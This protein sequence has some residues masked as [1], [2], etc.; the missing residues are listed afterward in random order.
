MSKNSNPNPNQHIADYL[1]HYL[2]Q[3]NPPHY[4]VMID[5]PWGIGKTFFIKEL[6]QK[7]FEGRQDYVYISLYGLETIE[8]I[9]KTLLHSLYPILF[10]KSSKIV[11]KVVKTGL[12]YFGLN[13]K[14]E[15][16]IDDALSKFQAKT[17]VFDDLERSSI[18]LKKVMGY[19]NEFI[20][21][22][23]CKVIVIANSK[24]IKKDDEQVFQEQKE[25]IIGRTF[26]AQSELDNALQKFIEEISD[27]STREIYIK[28][29]NSIKNIYEQS[30]L[31]NL[32]ILQQVLWDFERLYIKIK[33]NFK[34]EDSAISQLLK[35]FFALSYEFRS[36]RI[37]SQDLRN[38]LNQIVSGLTL[39]RKN[40]ELTPFTEANNRYS[41]IELYD[42]I[43]SDEVLEEILIKGIIDPVKINE[44]LS[45]SECFLDMPEEPSWRKLWRAIELTDI[46]FENAFLDFNDKFNAG[47]YS[48]PGE[49]LHVFGIRLW[50][51][52]MGYFGNS[53]TNTE[54]D[55]KKYV[56]KL[57]AEEKLEPLPLN[58]SYENFQ[59]QGYAGLAVHEN[60]TNELLNTANYL[61]SKREHLLTET[62]PKL[63]E[64]LLRELSDDVSLFHRRINITNS[65][66]NLYYDTPIF[67]YI[68]PENFIKILL[69]LNPKSQIRALNSFK[70]RYQ[71]NKLNRELATEK[72]WVSDVYQKLTEAT[73]DKSILSKYRLTKTF[74]DLFNTIT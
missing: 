43:I 32:R 28:N 65:E 55:C 26:T 16:D 7:Y 58:S 35:L 48:I 25:K 11:S 51:T 23:E 18:S 71:G 62:Y 1:Q 54:D 52:K 19:I 47:H 59:F 50:L 44:C 34:K 70:T 12:T 8:D 15:F 67:Q 22:D 41:E 31:D 2:S 74:E 64:D 30:A 68:K 42:T 40:G 49:I 36:G 14:I 53:L 13:G 45:H 4:A 24:E 72:Q 46:D 6:L 57:C 10:S 3:I 69:K 20:E 56:D 63:G 60:D 61:K 21:H 37:N 39:Q 38:R 73:K 5:G 9:N 66:D 29:I 33:P 27:T 17:Y